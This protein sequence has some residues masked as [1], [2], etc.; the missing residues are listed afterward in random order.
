MKRFLMA[1]AGLCFLLAVALTGC[2]RHTSQCGVEY[3]VCEP[4]AVNFSRIDPPAEAA[5]GKYAGFD[6][7]EIE[8]DL[9]MF[10][11]AE[12][13]AVDAAKAAAELPPAAPEPEAVPDPELVAEEPELEVEPA[14][15]PDAAPETNEFSEEA[16][17][18][19]IQAI[20]EEGK[21]ERQSI[22][23]I[24]AEGYGEVPSVVSA[25][26]VI[27]PEPI[28][29]PEPVIAESE[30]EPE[31]EPEI[32][33]AEIVAEAAEEA[34]IAAALIVEEPDPEPEFELEHELEVAEEVAEEIEVS[35]KNLSLDG[36]DDMDLDFFGSI[37]ESLLEADS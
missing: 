18:E 20:A 33:V 34:D 12:A 2:T 37:S 6:D 23:D 17:V 21:G 7:V 35:E 5:P 30:P 3:C 32:A 11:E 26:P 14:P 25:E 22:L 8:E 29:A 27:V 15:E 31:I 19:K 24:I 36:L 9:V 10:G 16:M 13:E 28:I 4:E 1:M